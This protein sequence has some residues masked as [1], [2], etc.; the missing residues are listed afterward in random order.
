[1]DE[2]IRKPA[3]SQERDG[4]SL[5]ALI[6][7]HVRLAIEM[8]VHEELRAAL[9]AQPYER[10]GNRRGYRNGT[11]A[12][13]LT[14][15]SGPVALTVPRAKLFGT[16]EWTSTILPRYQR[17]MPEVN[18][19]IVATYL[20]GGNTRRIRGALQPLLKGAPLSKSAVSRVIATL[21]D[22]LEA[23]RT[24]SLVDLDVIYVY[25]DGFALRVRSAGKVVS[26]PVL[27]VVGVLPDG[28]KHLL[29]LELCGG[30]P[31]RRG[32][33]VSMISGRVGYGRRYSRSSTVT[34]G[35]GAPSAW[36]GPGPRS[37]V[38]AYT[39]CA[40]WSGKRRSTRWRRSAMTSTASSTRPMRTRP[41]PRMR[42]SSARAAS[43]ARGR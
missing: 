8:A 40:I 35:C 12:R 18:E 14:G 4:V 42:P 15:P 13:T 17:R 16:R 27:A 43:A 26:V 39:S 28:H 9:G 10:N 41:A 19:A 11:K 31:S 29:A 3:A 33:A 2:R 38:A 25:L 30:S 22:G 23:W 37:S 32:R 21:R 20:A 34:P 6:H 5:G 7:Q 1:M 36:C 24:R